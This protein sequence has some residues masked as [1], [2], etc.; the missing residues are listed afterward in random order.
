MPKG[1]SRKPKTMSK[2]MVKQVEKVVEKALSE[3]LEEKRAIQQYEGK[4][5]NNVIA[6]GNVTSNNTNYFDLLAPITQVANS[7]S[8]TGAPGG[9]Y[10]F[11]IGDEVNLK[12]VKIKGFAYLTDVTAAQQLN[13]HI[14]VRIMI[15]KQKDKDSSVGF[16]ADSHAN[17]LLLDQV[18]ASGYQGPGSFNGAP[19]DLIREINRN[20]YS[21]RY[22]K[23]I[24]L[25]RDL[26]GGTSNTTRYSASTQKALKFFEHELTFGKGKKLNFTDGASI[27][28][29]NFPYLL[30]CGQV[31]MADPTTSQP[32]GLT[33]ISFTSTAEYTDA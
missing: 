13:T 28:P 31:N 11:R 15:L 24:Y 2:N 7:R 10:G 20:E 9:A 33:E 17:K 26:I 29:N 21:V 8:A 12:R 6:S 16:R 5:I 18:G 14:G 22:D 23:V 1:S 30:V 25:S 32:D 4:G 19:L 27:S 3:E